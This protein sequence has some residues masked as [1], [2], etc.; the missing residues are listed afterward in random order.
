MNDTTTKQ[1][2][3]TDAPWA[4]IVDESI[5]NALKLDLLSKEAPLLPLYDVAVIGGGIAGLSAARA[6]A[7]GGAR[8]VLLE[9]AHAL[10]A[11]ASGKNAGILGAGVNTPLVSMPSGHPAMAMWKSTSELLPELY[12]LADDKANKLIA[13]KAGALSLAKSETAKRRLQQ[14]ARARNNAGLNAEIITAAQV[15]NLTFEL[16]DLQGVQAALYLPDEGRINPLTLLAFLAREARINGCTLFGGAEIKGR[17]KTSDT[18][19]NLSTS[20]NVDV[21]ASKLIYA[22]GPV[23]NANRRIYAI[24]FRI[25]LPESFPLFWDAAPFTYYDY[26]SGEGYI[27]VTGGRYGTAGQTSA[28]DKFHNAMI[29]AAKNWMPALRKLEPSNIWAVNLEVASDMMPEI[30]VLEKTPEAYAIQGLGALG[31]LPG[32]VLGKEC[33]AKIATDLA[34]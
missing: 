25:D 1:A 10:A 30:V 27:T 8:V 9:R 18:A 14:E 26:R 16:L 3:Q 29:A 31:V 33:G 4:E 22:T 34:Y 32:M 19:W 20:C 2:Q 15:A 28:D 5:L 23:I 11:G 17:T 7:K 21:V 13:K 12:A 6:A 24:S